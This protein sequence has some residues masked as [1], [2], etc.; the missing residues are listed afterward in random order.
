M[1]E[2]EAINSDGLI[3]N[4]DGINDQF[5]EFEKVFVNS[6]Y[7]ADISEDTIY[8]TYRT[9]IQISH[10]KGFED[11]QQYHRDAYLRLKLRD[12]H[13]SQPIIPA[14]EECQTDQEETKDENPIYKQFDRK[15]KIVQGFH[16][17]YEHD[18]KEAK[19]AIETLK[20]AQLSQ[21]ENFKTLLNEKI[22][23]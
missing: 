14:I 9:A 23:N 19:A 7:L 5:D 18:L 15:V 1:I 12:L 6:E 8:Q 20:Q 2:V 11:F 21:S 22:A 16:D 3:K 17:S 10:S 13:Y 4:I